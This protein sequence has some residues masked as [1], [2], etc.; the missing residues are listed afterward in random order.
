MTS[1]DQP[2]QFPIYSPLPVSYRLIKNVGN[3]FIRGGPHGGGVIVDGRDVAV[4]R[5][6]I[7]I[8]E[9]LLEALLVV[10]GVGKAD[11]DLNGEAVRAGL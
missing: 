4:G 5:V 11:F 10:P 9:Y 3:Y 7:K 2:I 6:V 1:R 8:L